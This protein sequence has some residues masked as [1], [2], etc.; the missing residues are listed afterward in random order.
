MAKPIKHVMLDLETLAVSPEAAV[1]QIGMVYYDA[2]S[3]LPVS[4]GISISPDIYMD[5]MAYFKVDPRTIA[6]HEKTNPQNYE[7]CKQST[8]SLKKAAELVREVISDAKESETYAIWLWCCGTDFDIPI[9]MHFLAYSG[10]KPNWSYSYVRD[11]RTL[12]EMYKNIVPL[13]AKGD[14][15]ALRDAMVQYNH[16]MEIL[17]Y[18]GQPQT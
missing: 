4:R 9:I 6:F 3:D 14:H 8:V 7:Y 15:S 13:T 5:K 17:D 2:A 18:V 1:I 12:R 11:Y 10:L 16:L